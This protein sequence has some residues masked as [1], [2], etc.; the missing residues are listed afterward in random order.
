MRVVVVLVDQ[1]ERPLAVGPKHG[2]GGH[3]YMT[4][5]I[6]Y[7]TRGR[8]GSVL[9]TNRLRPL[10]G[11]KLRGE[12]LRG[13]RLDLVILVHHEHVVGSPTVGASRVG[14]RIRQGVIVE[15]SFA[16]RGQ[17]SCEGVAQPQ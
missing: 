15:S 14:R 10:L 16:S 17:K 13:A 12:K 7:I 1:H 6:F 2:I 4:L 8:E 3:Q 5:G 11:E 9:G